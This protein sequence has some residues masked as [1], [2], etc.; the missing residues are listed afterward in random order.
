MKTNEPPRSNQD[1]KSLELD[2]KIK[3]FLD[4]GGEIKTVPTGVSGQEKV[5]KSS[6]V[7]PPP[8]DPSMVRKT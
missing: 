3:E 6:F 5:K 7:I 8:W 2:Q 4:N 1:E